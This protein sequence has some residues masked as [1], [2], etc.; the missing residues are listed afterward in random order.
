MAEYGACARPPGVSGL[1]HA[2][3]VIAL[4]PSVVCDAPPDAVSWSQGPTAAMFL[5]VS[6]QP[7]SSVQQRVETF[8]GTESSR[9][10]ENFGTPVKYVHRGFA[11]VLGG[12]AAVSL[13][14]TWA[15]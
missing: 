6:S 3:W 1:S 13:V 14:N 10:E 15:L 8:V 2:S 4:L 7:A 5:R 9:V 12:E 11:P